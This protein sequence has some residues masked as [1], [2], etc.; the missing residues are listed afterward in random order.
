MNIKYEKGELT[1]IIIHFLIDVH[2]TPSTISRV[3]LPRL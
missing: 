2:N 3:T 1:F